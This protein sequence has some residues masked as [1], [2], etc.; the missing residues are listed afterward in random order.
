[1]NVKRAKLLTVRRIQSNPADF[2]Q[3]FILLRFD[4]EN[5]SAMSDLAHASDA[6]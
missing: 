5:S 4:K 1:M 3:E 6:A 2:N